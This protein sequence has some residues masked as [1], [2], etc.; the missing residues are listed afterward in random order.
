MRAND[1]VTQ[2]PGPD[3]DGEPALDVGGFPAVWVFHGVVVF[4]V[5]VD[6]SVTSKH[7]L[8]CENNFTQKFVVGNIVQIDLIKSNKKNK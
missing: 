6:G 4:V 8:V 2:D 3:I 5:T 7:A 1:P